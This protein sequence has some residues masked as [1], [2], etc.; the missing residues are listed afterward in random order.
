MEM[1]KTEIEAVLLGNI[2]ICVWVDFE[3]NIR[4]QCEMKK[5]PVE[6][7]GGQG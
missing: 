1:E 5:I 6:F 3:I 4:H 7:E 2:K